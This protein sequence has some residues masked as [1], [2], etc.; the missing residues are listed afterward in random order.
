MHA[1]TTVLQKSLS[2]AFTW[3]HRAR[4]NVLLEAVSAFILGRRL[5]KNRDSYGDCPCSE[6]LSPFF[7]FPGESEVASAVTTMFPW[8]A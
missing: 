1:A 3:M 4:V 8:I 7:I 6:G 5:V 2:S